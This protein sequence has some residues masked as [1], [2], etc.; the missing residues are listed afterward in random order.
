M[1][2]PEVKINSDHDPT[3]RTYVKDSNSQFRSASNCNAFVN[4]KITSL[5]FV[6]KDV[7]AQY[8]HF[9]AQKIPVLS[10]IAPEAMIDIKESNVQGL[11]VVLH[12]IHEKFNDRCMDLSVDDMWKVIEANLRYLDESHFLKL[13]DWFASW[14]DG[15]DKSSLSKEDYLKLAVPCRRF[16]NPLGLLKVTRYLAFNVPVKIDF[17]YPKL[18]VVGLRIEPRL[19]AGLN[20]ARGSLGT[21]LL[22]CVESIEKTI[23]ESKCNDVCKAM[24]LLAVKRGLDQCYMFP[25]RQQLH[26]KRGIYVESAINRLKNF[27]Y[28]PARGACETC[29]RDFGQKLQ[30][31][32]NDP[33]R[34]FEGLCLGCVVDP[35]DNRK[36]GYGRNNKFW[37]DGC[38]KHGIQHKEPSCY[39]SW[40]ASER[41][42]DQYLDKFEGFGNGGLH[43]IHEPTC[44]DPA[45]NGHQENDILPILP[46]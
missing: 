33:R 35:T 39:F 16:E 6:R 21:I 24:S 12:A 27:N 8:S 20:S 37:G 4:G 23:Y 19:E 2:C 17:I 13:K 29:S 18:N 5:F 40:V 14:L 46:Y 45:S 36:G 22:E 11:E 41:V 28:V 26:G 25:P 3:I 31:M 9:L 15:L 1:A 38:R 30:Q 7:I 10:H 32:L 44:P 34:M 42:R 43:P